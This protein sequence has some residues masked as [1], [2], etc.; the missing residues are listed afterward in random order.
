MSLFSGVKAHLGSY[1]GGSDVETGI[2]GVGNPL[3]VNLHQLPDALQ[4]FSFIE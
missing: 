4:Q 3:L 2:L 1:K